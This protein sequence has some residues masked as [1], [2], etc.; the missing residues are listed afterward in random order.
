MEAQHE[1]EFRKSNTHQSPPH[2]SDTRTVGR[3]IRHFPASHFPMGKR[4]HL[5]RHRN[6]SYDWMALLS[7][8]GLKEYKEFEMRCSSPALKGFTLKSNYYWSEKGEKDFCMIHQNG[9]GVWIIPSD[10]RDAV[11]HEWFESLRADKRFDPLFKRLEKCVIY[12]EQ[13]EE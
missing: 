3:K 9:W 8:K 11:K 10:Y 7:Q 2:E 4:H 13:T 1:V 12:K 5:P 6:A